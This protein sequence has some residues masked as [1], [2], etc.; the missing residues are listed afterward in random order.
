[1]EWARGYRRAFINLLES[2]A[3]SCILKG[4]NGPFERSLKGIQYKDIVYW[5][6]LF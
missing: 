5:I 2:N 1:M 4:Y 6:L 3:L